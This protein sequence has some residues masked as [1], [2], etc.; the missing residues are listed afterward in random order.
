[1]FAPVLGAVLGQSATRPTCG[2]SFEAY[3]DTIADRH[4]QRRSPLRQ[5][6]RLRDV[7]TGSNVPAL[8]DALRIDHGT[9]G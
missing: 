3:T 6:P 9:L 5:P 7:D 1:V 4:Q 2:P 8:A